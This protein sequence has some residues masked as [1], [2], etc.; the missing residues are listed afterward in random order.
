MLKTLATLFRLFDLERI[1]T[2][3]TDIREGFFV[4]NKE[5]KIRLAQRQISV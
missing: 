2:D 1:H 5:C 4:K 3:E